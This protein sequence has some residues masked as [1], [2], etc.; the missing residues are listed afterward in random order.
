MRLLIKGKNVDVSPQVRAYAEKRLGKLSKLLDDDATR[1]ELE[2][3]EER[4]P[5]VADSHI[6]EAT[7]W[8]K[9]PTLRAHEAAPDIYEAIDLVTDKLSRQVR[10]LHERRVDHRKGIAGNGNG[11]HGNGAP[12]LP[13]EGSLAALLAVEGDVH[14]RTESVMA[15]TGELRIVKTKQF[16]L[17][18]MTPEEAAEHM[19]LVGHDFFVFVNEENN[20]TCVLYRRSDGALG[21]IEPAIAEAEAS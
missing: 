15:G 9:G 2:L 13:D 10:S 6:A 12:M 11:T 20:Q 19:G 21:L 8:T 17:G 14:E 18:P 5:R 16:R 3:A 7:I 4:N 1:L